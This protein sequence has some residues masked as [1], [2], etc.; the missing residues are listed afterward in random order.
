MN[1]EYN[2]TLFKNV[3]V[4]RFLPSDVFLFRLMLG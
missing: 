3:D 4:T 1:R 2:Y